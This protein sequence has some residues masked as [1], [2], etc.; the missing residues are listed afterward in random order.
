MSQEVVEDATLIRTLRLLGWIARDA[1]ARWT[2]N[3]QGLLPSML[4]LVSILLPLMPLLPVK[5]AI[6]RRQSV[7][8][9]EHRYNVNC[10]IK[11][12]YRKLIL[13]TI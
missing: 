3:R 9:G 11:T 10:A 8:L 2:G 1:T 7:N 13:P 5:A 6:S 4:E 12:I